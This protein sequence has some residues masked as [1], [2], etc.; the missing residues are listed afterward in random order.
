VALALGQRATG[1]CDPVEGSAEAIRLAVAG[2]IGGEPV[3]STRIIGF[4]AKRLDF[5]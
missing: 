1:E 3:N 5:G 4:T 2:M